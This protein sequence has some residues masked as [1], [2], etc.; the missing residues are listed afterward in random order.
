MA[1]IERGH[2]FTDGS[3]GND[4]ADLHELVDAA[5]ILPAF[6][7]SK[8]EILTIEDADVFAVYDNSAAAIRKINFENIV[9]SLPT[10]E[11]AATAS[12]R[13]LGTTSTKAAAG[14]DTRFPAN[15]TGVRLGAGAA[16]NDAAATPPDLSFDSYDLSGKT[17]IDWDLSDV[18]HENLSADKTYTFAN[19]TPG[20]VIHLI[21]RR[22]GHAITLPVGIGSIVVG[23]GITLQHCI[24]TS[25]DI[26]I[27][28]LQIAI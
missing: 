6:F 26:G 11:V 4:S 15:V 23:T 14:N 16:S 12:L 28:G 18:F 21:V 7:T 10:N 2:T 3:S 19:T 17:E 5:T 20:R 1:D 24:F 9:A 25:S 8:T 13:S 22:N 27:T